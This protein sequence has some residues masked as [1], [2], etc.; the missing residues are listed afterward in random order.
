MMK[1]LLTIFGILLLMM[2]ADAQDS[3]LLR[4]DFLYAGEGKRIR[5]YIVKDGQVT[6]QFE[7]KDW[8]G[9]EIS[10]AILL[11][12]G[13]ILMAYRNGIAEVSQ[14]KKI[15]WNYQAPEGTE[16]HTIQPIG[17]N[18]VAFE[19]Q[20]SKANLLLRFT[21]RNSRLVHQQWLTLFDLAGLH[22][23]RIVGSTSFLDRCAAALDT[24][25]GLGRDAFPER[26]SLGRYDS[27]ERQM[28]KISTQFYF[29]D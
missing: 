22:A 11:T 29:I 15:V 26:P 28:V 14:D 9:G 27:N 18:H 17:K 3:Q 1:R 25:E 13:H 5:M 24:G 20:L 10:D 2:A 7:N 4:H 23:P 12:D 16:I 8:Q 6:W 21:A 19:S